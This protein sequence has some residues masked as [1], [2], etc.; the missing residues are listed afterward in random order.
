MSEAMVFA[1]DRLVPDRRSLLLFR[2]GSQTYAFAVESIVQIVSMV[3]IIT[4]PQ[5][6]KT[7]EGVINVQGR[8]VPVVD[9]RRHLGLQE[10]QF[11]LYTPILLIRSGDWILGLI[12]DEVLDVLNLCPEE[13]TPIS[14]ILPGDLGQALAVRDLVR[15][16]DGMSLLLD[17]EYLFA[18]HQRE[19]LSQAANWLPDSALEAG[20]Q[21]PEEEDPGALLS[22]EDGA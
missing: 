9:M 2:L 11:D 16:S 4:L 5:L 6:D 19:A 21:G 18:P 22:P 7:V 8:I 17:P 12:V 14:E 20:L 10:V 3:A 13:F 15:A 1:K